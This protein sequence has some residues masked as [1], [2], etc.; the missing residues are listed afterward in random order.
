MKSHP[1]FRSTLSVHVYCS[2]RHMHDSFYNLAYELVRFSSCLYNGLHLRYMDGRAVLW[3]G[4]D[5][6]WGRH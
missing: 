3:V 4:L 5:Y 2:P 6:G 1:S